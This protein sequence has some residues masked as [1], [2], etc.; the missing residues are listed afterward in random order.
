MK[1][2]HSTSGFSILEC[3][4][5][6]AVLGVVLSLAYTT[7][8]RL[9]KYSRDLRRN[10]DDIARTLHAGERWRADVRAAVGPLK[11]VEDGTENG[12]EIPQR[13]GAVVY[14]FSKG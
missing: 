12:L 7:F 3:L 6:I 13:S 4:V 11:V 5:Y 8:Y 2:R 9:S 1:T 14:S 10:T